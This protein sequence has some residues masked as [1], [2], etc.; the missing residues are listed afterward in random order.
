MMRI[1]QLL[2]KTITLL[3]GFQ[4]CT[5]ELSAMQYAYMKTKMADVIAANVNI[6]HHSSSS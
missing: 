1:S 3:V 5:G 4:L 6:K 2:V